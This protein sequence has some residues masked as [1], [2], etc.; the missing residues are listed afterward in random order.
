MSEQKSKE[1]SKEMGQNSDSDLES[2]LEKEERESVGLKSSTFLQLMAI[3]LRHPKALWRGLFMIVVGT[4]STLLEPRIFALAIDDAILPKRWD[5][6]QWIGGGFILVTC[7]RVLAAVQQGYFFEVL[8]QKVTQDLRVTLFSHLQRMPVGIFDRNPTGRL[9]TRVTNDIAALNE[10]FSA[11]FVSMVC[12]VLLVAGIL[13]GLLALDLRLGLI[14]ISVFPILALSSVYFSRKLKIAY[15]DSRS[16]LSALNSFLAENLSGMKT[17]HLFNRQNLHLFRFEKLNQSYSEA[18]TGTIRVFALFQPTITVAAGLSIGLMIWFGG[19]EALSGSL[20]LGILVAYFS[21][22]L[23]LFQPVREIADKWNLFLSGM[24]SAERVF[25]LLEWATEFEAEA[26]EGSVTQLPDIRGDL[27]FEN[28][29]FSYESNINPKKWVLQDFSLEIKAGERIGVVGHTGAGKT[30]LISLLMRFY[31][32][33]RGRI[34]LD[35][36]DLRSMDRRSLRATMGIVQQDVFLFS[37]SLKEN[38]T[39]WKSE[40]EQRVV[41]LLSRLKIENLPE[42]R[43]QERGFNFSMGE[44]QV[45]AFARTLVACPKIWILDEATSSMDSETERILQQSMESAS[46]HCTTLLIAHRL[47]TVRSA[48]RIIVLNQGQLVEAGRHDDLMEKDGYYARLYRYQQSQEYLSVVRDPNVNVE[49][50]QSIS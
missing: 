9:L 6:L 18:Q 44:R 31:E 16:K 23:A 26:V 39:F 11:G 36:K 13:I 22:V 1:A 46:A 20:K 33:Q 12:N 24:A 15:R 50:G 38:V 48:D 21:Y 30:T 35:G 27:V 5:R 43:I 25:G 8:G 19:K 42:E 45:I 37:G 32:P 4:V 17:V 14:A 3:I 2:F 49:L 7:T 10:M 28:V 47:A 41:E 40:N 34:L 29:W